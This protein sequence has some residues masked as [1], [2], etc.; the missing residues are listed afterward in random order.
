MT[1]TNLEKVRKF[2]RKNNFKLFSWFNSFFGKESAND[3]F[4]G[5]KHI[6]TL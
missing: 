5:I 2:S 6:E 1:K 3:N 4:I